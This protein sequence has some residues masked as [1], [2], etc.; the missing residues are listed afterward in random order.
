MVR[1]RVQG[2]GFRVF[3]YDEARTLGL[4]GY[5]RNGVDRRQVKVVT[6]GE[7][8]KIELLIA[9]LRQGPSMAHVESVVV[10]WQPDSEEY[11]GFRIRD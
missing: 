2:V 3:V 4:S 7:V 10:T 5:V 9:R 8:K 1:G 6:C 11:A